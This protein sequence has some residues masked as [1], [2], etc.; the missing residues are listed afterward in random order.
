MRL[1]FF[2]A[3]LVAILLL[4]INFYVGKKLPY[5]YNTI[6]VMP[7][8][9]HGWYVN[10]KQIKRLIEERN[11]KIIVEVGSWLGSSTMHFATTLP[12]GGKVYAVDHWLGSKEEQTEEYSVLLKDLYRQFLSNIIHRGLVS[13]VIPIRMESLEASRSL[14]VIPDL[15][16][17]DASPDTA[18]VYNDL[19]AWFPFVKGHGVICGD[20]WTCE[21]VKEAARKFADEHHFK[22]N[23]SENFWQIVE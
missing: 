23:Y 19:K 17:L 20:D 7:Y 5:P 10:S 22:I 18:S 8:K 2:I 14:N 16:Y 4:T 15:V 9:E 21:S 3:A 1:F 6:K 11:V 13:K 12:K